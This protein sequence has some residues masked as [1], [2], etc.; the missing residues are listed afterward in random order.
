M[1][2]Q[3]NQGKP[4][5]LPGLSFCHPS[6]GRRTES[7]SVA[8]I[9]G[10]S[11]EMLKAKVMKS[12]REQAQKSQNRISILVPLAPFRGYSFSVNP[13]PIALAP[14]NQTQSNRYARSNWRANLCKH[15]K[16]SNLHLT[17][18]RTQSKP[19]KVGQSDL[20]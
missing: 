9:L 12:S 7:Q 18:G 19:V 14:G 6:A 16:I 10:K 5:F 11:W 4:I 3:K 17:P 13:T 15:L 8:V 2:G 20:T 1:L